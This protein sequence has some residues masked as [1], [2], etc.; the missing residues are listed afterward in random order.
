MSDD[1]LKEPE[2]PAWE[3]KTM[4]QAVADDMEE[5]DALLDEKGGD[6]EAAEAKFDS[7]VDEVNQ[8][9]VRPQD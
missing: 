5:A 8:T 7:D 1:P 4:G 3:G 6:A 9:P 2:N